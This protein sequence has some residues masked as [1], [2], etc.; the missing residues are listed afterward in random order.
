MAQKTYGG[1]KARPLPRRKPQLDP[2]QRGVRRLVVKAPA[3]QA[4][5][6]MG[7]KCPVLRD[8]DRDT[9]HYALEVLAGVLD[10][11]ESARLNQSLVRNSRLATKV[12]AG[13]DSTSR[14]PGMCYLDG[15]PSQGKS[16]AELEAGLRA[17]LALVAQDGVT[18]TELARAKAQVVASQVYKRD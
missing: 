6:L 15:A 9:E 18:E 13:Y 7:W 16:A 12:G 1:I 8:V 10:G 2:E 3:D 17:E 4:Y 5:L 14:G 11:N